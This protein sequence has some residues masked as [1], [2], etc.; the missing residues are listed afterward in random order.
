MADKQTYNFTSLEKDAFT[1]MLYLDQVKAP[2]SAQDAAAR[3]FLAA[4]ALK[5]TWEIG[6]HK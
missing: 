4:T 2:E 5:T 6:G 1:L 3:I